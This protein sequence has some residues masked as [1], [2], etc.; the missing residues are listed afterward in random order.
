[1]DFLLTGIIIS[2]LLNLVR[3][4]FSQIRLWLDNTSNFL[5][6]DLSNVDQF[7]LFYPSIP[8]FILCYDKIPYNYYSIIPL[9]SL[10]LSFLSI[11]LYLPLSYRVQVNQSKER[12]VHS[13]NWVRLI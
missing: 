5:S 7:L 8:P 3:I 10:S 9:F 12:K 6:N 4:I 2:K 11:L 13:E 1:M